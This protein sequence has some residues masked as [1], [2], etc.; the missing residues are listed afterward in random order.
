MAIH[1]TVS[2]KFHQEKDSH[3]YFTEHKLVAE[4]NK[5]H[6]L[7]FLKESYLHWVVK[8]TSLTKNSLFWIIKKGPHSQ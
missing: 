2:F 8:D 4:Q 3:V 5:T 1:K 7:S 6:I